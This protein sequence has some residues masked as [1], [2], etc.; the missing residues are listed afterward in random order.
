MSKIKA[1]FFLLFISCSLLSPAGNIEIVKLKTEYA[2]TPLGIDVSK[3]RFSWQMYA[4]EQGYTQTAYQIIVNDETGQRVWNTGKV[5]SD[6]S[7]NIKYEGT[8]LKPRTRY[9]WQLTVW[10]QEK[11]NTWPRRGSKPD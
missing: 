4:N 5:K 7:L 6:V 9:S 2:V 10:D 8:A 3:P 11:K 1:I